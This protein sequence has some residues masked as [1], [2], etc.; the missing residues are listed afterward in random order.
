MT[1]IET[2]PDREAMAAAAADAVVAA[3]REGIHARGSAGL[4]ATGGSSPGPT[5]DRLA[6]ADLDWSRVRVTLSDERWV[7]LASP[8]SNE[9]LVRGRLLTG[10]AAAASFLPLRGM[11]ASMAAAADAASTVLQAW[12]AF[13]VVILGMGE[14]GHIASLFP[15]NPTLDPGLAAG[16][17]ACIAVPVSPG[18]DPPLARLSLTLPRLADTGLVLILT[19]GAVKRGILEEAL[20][21]ADPH[22]YPVAAILR[23]G[24]N[25]RI[26]WSA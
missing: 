23:S 5:Y 8:Q 10:R 13:D 3:L 12:P 22:R 24:A 26:L 6:E 17:P 21:G 18:M 1:T 19:S 16:A 9:R 14:N 20:A 11:A 25:L 4:V 7:D 15:D 2:Y